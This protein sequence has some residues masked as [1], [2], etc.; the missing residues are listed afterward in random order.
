MLDL[1]AA[2]AEQPGLR[3]NSSGLLSQSCSWIEMVSCL[4]SWLLQQQCGY[5]TCFGG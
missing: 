2:P 4:L 3:V 5:K 1:A